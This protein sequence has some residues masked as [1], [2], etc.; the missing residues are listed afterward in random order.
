MSSFT[1]VS[2]VTRTL[3]TV[4]NTATGVTVDTERSPADTISDAASL[5]HLYLYRVEQNPFFTNLEPARATP[6][7]I[8]EPSLGLNLFYLVTPYG[9]GQL[10]IQLTLGEILRV[11]HDSPVID[12][13]HYDPA[14]QDTTEELRVI[15]APLSL[16]ELTELWRAFD[17]RSYR[18][19][20]SYEVSVALIDSEISR[21]VVPVEERRVRVA[22]W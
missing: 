2:G 20:L 13:V 12:P 14:V 3:A 8:R 17:G 11:F 18:L 6:T 7:Q 10:Q 16:Q 4:L 15:P 5:I 9:N 22:P 21:V 1:V 19:S